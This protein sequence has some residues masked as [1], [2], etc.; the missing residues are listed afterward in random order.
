MTRVTLRGALRAAR[1][2][3]LFELLLPDFFAT[4]FFAPFLRDILAD[5]FI[6]LCFDRFL[7]ARLGP[8][9]A[10]FFLAMVNPS[11]TD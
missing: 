9:F 10:A 8:F 7:V 2:A 11:V 3:D 5:F 4:L 1:L 6:D